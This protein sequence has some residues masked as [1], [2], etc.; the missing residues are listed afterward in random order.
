MTLKTTKQERAELWRQ[1]QVSLPLQQLMTLHL[2]DVHLEEDPSLHMRIEAL[3]YVLISSINVC[4]IGVRAIF[5]V[6]HC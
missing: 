5:L 2:P 4:R 3:A 6:G 1:R